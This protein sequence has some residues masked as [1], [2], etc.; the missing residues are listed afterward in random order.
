MSYI[1]FP[2]NLVL[3]IITQK[4]SCYLRLIGFKDRNI[5]KL[6]KQ[7]LYNKSIFCEIDCDFFFNYF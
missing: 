6:I 3:Q 1:R 7:L 2:N 5:E 4:K